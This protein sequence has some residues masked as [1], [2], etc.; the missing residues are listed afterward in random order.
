MQHQSVYS[1][2]STNKVFGHEPTPFDV[3]VQL[4]IP[5][6]ERI[7]SIQLMSMELPVGFY[8]IRAGCNTLAFTTTKSGSAPVAYTIT[9][10]PAN[11]T[12]TTLITALQTAINAVIS[13]TTCTITVDTTVN[14]VSISLTSTYNFSITTDTVLSSVI[15]GFSSAQTA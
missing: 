8:N 9:R 2:K 14:K 15:L 7:S 1:H 12:I 11:Y 13:G 10:T 3:I 6:R 5:T 4:D